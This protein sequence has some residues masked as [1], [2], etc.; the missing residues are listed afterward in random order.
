MDEWWTY[1]PSDFL[2]FSRDTYVQL[3]EQYHA[4]VWP[5]HLVLLAA[6]IAVAWL[7]RR[8]PP[9]GGRAITALLAVQWAWVGWAFHESHFTSINPMAGYFAAAFYAQAALLAVIGAGWGRLTVVVDRSARASAALAV[10]LTAIVGVPLA[11]MLAGRSWTQI[12]IAGMTP[13]ATAIGTL[14]VLLLL[15][16]RMRPTLLVIPAVWCGLA[17]V[18]HWTMASRPEAVVVLLAV[19][20]SGFALLAGRRLSVQQA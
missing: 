17:G 18:M 10:L 2:L 15:R 19:A 8:A 16:G 9:L 5:A 14:G 13:D 3:F 4:S 7:L 11:G 20:L 1:R 12:E 6:W